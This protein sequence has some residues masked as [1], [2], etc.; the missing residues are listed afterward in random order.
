MT[1]PGPVQFVDCPKC[2]YD[3]WDG[4]LCPK[5]RLCDYHCKCPLTLLE[6]AGIS[7][8]LPVACVVVPPV[9]LGYWLKG[10]LR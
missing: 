2:G 8:C 1:A 4:T 5:C 3:Q 7:L 10:K 9:L 6:V